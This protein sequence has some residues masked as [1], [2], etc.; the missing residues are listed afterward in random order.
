MNAKVPYDIN[1]SGGWYEELPHFSCAS[2]GTVKAGGGVREGSAHEGDWTTA[3]KTIEWMRQAVVSHPERPLFVYQGTNIVHPPYV[4]NGYWN[5][6]IDRSKIHV[7]EWKPLLEMHACDF[8]SS[9]L[10]G[11]TPSDADAPAFYDVARRREVRAKYYA[12]IAEFDAMVG[13][14]VETIDDLGLTNTTVFVV[15]SDHGDMQME[16]QQ[17]YKMVPYDASAS[18][19]MV[20]YDGRNPL[21]APAVVTAPTQLIDLFPTFLEL[22]HAPKGAY[23][24]HLDGY[25]L[26]HM[27]QPPSA[28]APMLQQNIGKQQMDARPSFVVSQFHGDDIA[29]SWFLIVKRFNASATYKL[30]VWGTGAEVGVFTRLRT[31]TRARTRSRNAFITPCCLFPSPSLL[32]SPRGVPSHRRSPT[33]SSSSQAIPTRTTISCPPTPTRTHTHRSSKSSWLI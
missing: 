30:I 4:T 23:P 33:F 27:L 17:H 20:I 14:Y 32:P 22:A 21:D 25:S 13:L 15:T 19:P 28:S 10:K 29:M 5:A 3:D 7:P 2:G 9:M 26:V 24:A 18:V 16:K 31:R 6:T 8:Q 1:A 11:C 12:M